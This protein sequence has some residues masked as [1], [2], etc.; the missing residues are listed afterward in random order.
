[1]RVEY[2][3]EP[4]QWDVPDEIHDRIDT[5][6][7]KMKHRFK[8]IRRLEKKLPPYRKLILKNLMTCKDV[9][10]V[11]YNKHLGPAII[12]TSTYIKRAFKKHLNTAT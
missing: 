9:L 10:I 4:K 6:S 8:K 2:D 3:W 5:F 1:M 12:N 7:S 11:S